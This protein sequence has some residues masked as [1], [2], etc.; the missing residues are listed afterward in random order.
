LV[1]LGL[2]S[3]KQKIVPSQSFSERLTVALKGF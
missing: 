2:E 3:H 1:D